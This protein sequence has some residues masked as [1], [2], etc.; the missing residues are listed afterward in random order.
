MGHVAEQLE[1]LATKIDRLDGKKAKVNVD[2]DTKDAGKG[3]DLIQSRWQ[4]IA[5]GIIVASPLIGAAILAGVGV[6]FIGIAALAQKSNQDVNQAYT[7]LWQDIKVG[8]KNATD[9]LV[10]QLVGGAH[11]IST[12][13]NQLGPQITQGM[14]LAGPE[15]VA[16]T[17]GVSE[18]AHNAMPGLLA[19]MQSNMPV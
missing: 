3:L 11:E 10:P 16:L 18:M 15:V 6:G 12:A 7:T 9:Q 8:A 2:V 5:A 17:R 14:A 4:A 13:V 19:A 1:M